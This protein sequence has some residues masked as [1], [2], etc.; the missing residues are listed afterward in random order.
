MKIVS[1]VPSQTELLYDLGL[2]TEVV[3]ITKF[4]IHPDE[5]YRNKIRIGGTKDLNLKK[6]RALNPSLI[7]ANKE[8]NTKEQI[9]ALSKEFY[10]FVSDIKTVKDNFDLIKTVGELT[11]R[12]LEAIL[13]TQRLKRAVDNINNGQTKRAA[14]IIWKEPLMV[15]G[16]D[17]FINSMMQLS[18]F[19]NV[20]KNETRYPEVSFEQLKNINPDYVLLSSEPYPFKEKHIEFFKK[21]LPFS[22]IKLVDGE[23]FS[24]YGT[25]IIKKQAYLKS[26]LNTVDSDNIST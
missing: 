10:V 22:R 12:N 11:N 3:G 19:E 18:G 23:A 25:R 26:V 6:I 16:G 5:W 2:S 4:C 15:A 17:T 14:Y 8:E 9:E 24:W 20:F 21:Q 1:T 13:Q 7:I